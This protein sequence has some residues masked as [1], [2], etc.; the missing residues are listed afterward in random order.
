MLY[1]IG[2]YSQLPYDSFPPKQKPRLSEGAARIDLVLAAASSYRPPRS[3]LELAATNAGRYKETIA[4]NIDIKV[5]DGSYEQLIHHSVTG[6]SYELYS[7]GKGFLITAGG[8][9]S[10]PANTVQLKGLVGGVVAQVFTLGSPSDAGTG[11]PTT[12]MLWDDQHATTIEELLQ[13]QGSRHGTGDT[14]QFDDN[15]CVTGGFACGT[16]ILVPDRACF[17]E[18]PSAPGWSFFDSG[19]CPR[20]HGAA[21][22]PYSSERRVLV[23]LFRTTC[24]GGQA[25]DCP[26]GQQ[27]GFFEVIDAGAG[28]PGAPTPT[29]DEFAKKVLRNNLGRE[30]GWVS[31]GKAVA[32]DYKA[33]DGRTITFSTSAHQ[34]NADRSGIDSHPP[35][36]QWPRATGPLFYDNDVFRYRLPGTTRGFDIE[37]TNNWPKRNDFVY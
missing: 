17:Q 10:P 12:L 29:L 1:Y 13:I 34:A 28:P 32:G 21:F 18:D 3:V 7:R 8:L 25:V 31:S 19:Q 35:L 27:M 24:S 6:G 22:D 36:S 26:D 16:V 2:D 37:M 5:D 30:A 9:T 23:A 15:L 33:F 11:L 20:K 4:A 14:L